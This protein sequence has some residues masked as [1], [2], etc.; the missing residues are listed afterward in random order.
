MFK[1][2]LN[3]EMCKDVFNYVFNFLNNQFKEIPKA[4]RILARKLS[5][6][7]NED[8]VLEIVLVVCLYMFF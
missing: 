5:K 2:L 8:K 7:Y 6:Y 1:P 3:N 4:Y